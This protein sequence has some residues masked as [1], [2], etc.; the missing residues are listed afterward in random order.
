MVEGFDKRAHTVVVLSRSSLELGN[1]VATATGGSTTV[2]TATG[3][4]TITMPAP[5]LIP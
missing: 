5:V 1:T 2:A 4:S 3:G